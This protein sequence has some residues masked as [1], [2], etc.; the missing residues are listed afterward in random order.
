MASTN[1]SARMSRY[2]ALL[3]LTFMASAAPALAAPETRTVTGN[4]VE[5]GEILPHA[6]EA[7]HAID[8]CPS[9]QVGTSRLLDRA[10]IERQV[11]SA[12]FDLGDLDV[13]SAVRV[14]RAGRKYTPVELGE[15]LNEPVSRALPPGVALVS[16]Q[17]SVTVTLEHDAKPGAIN[18][19]KLPRRLGSVRVAFTVEFH[20]EEAPIRVPVT[21]IVQVSAH[22]ATSAVA[23]G[24]RVQLTIQRGS[25]RIT[26]DATALGEGN[27]GDQLRFRV[28]STG[29]VLRGILISPTM[30]KVSD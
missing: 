3:A 9:P 24:A 25:A 27:V 10:L 21:A 18:L 20:G 17:P 1:L 16:V 8:I 22:A 15:L 12:G 30:A 26:A 11:S 14:E 13:P 19:P 5:L 23:R 4:R 2:S 29:K 6:P 28:S 7:M